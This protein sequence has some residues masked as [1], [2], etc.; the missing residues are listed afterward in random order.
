[1]NYTID[2]VSRLGEAFRFQDLDVEQ[3]RAGDVVVTVVTPATRRDTADLLVERADRSTRSPTGSNPVSC[4]SPANSASTIDTA[5]GST[6]VIAL[7]AF[8]W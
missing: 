8:F 6:G 5:S 4:T 2:I 7:V 3:V 1:M